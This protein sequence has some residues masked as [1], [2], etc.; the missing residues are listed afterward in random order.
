MIKKAIVWS[1]TASAFLPGVFTSGSRRALTAS[2]STLT[3]PPR[4]HP[5][6]C[7]SRDVSST[8]SVTGAPWTTRASTPAMC[9]HSSEGT[10]WYSLTLSSDG[11]LGVNSRSSTWKYS[12]LWSASR[13]EN[14]CRKYRG[15]MYE[16][17]TARIFIPVP[18]EPTTRPSLG[19]LSPVGESPPSLSHYNSI[20]YVQQWLNS[21]SWD[22]TDRCAGRSKR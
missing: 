20:L 10:P 6:I 16:S 3:G 13:E 18:F 15:G 1:A 8:S 21:G 22:L 12:T 14:A 5:T 17:P 19:A 2:T 4:A 7:S 9:S 11:E